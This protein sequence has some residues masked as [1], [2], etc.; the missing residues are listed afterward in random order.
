M[1]G[2]VD[3][4]DMVLLC[5]G[6]LEDGTGCDKEYHMYCLTPALR[7]IPEGL[8]LC[9]ECA[10]CAAKEAQVEPPAGES[11]PPQAA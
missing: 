2:G 11:P 4:E 8:W 10:K 3:N 6:K 5:D 7:E 9:D 1:C